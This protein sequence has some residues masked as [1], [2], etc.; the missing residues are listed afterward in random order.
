MEAAGAAVSFVSLAGPV[1]QGLKFLYDFTTDMKECPKEIREMRTDIDLVEDLITEVIQQC[2]G[3]DRRLRESAALA[4]AIHHARESVRDLGEELDKYR[5]DGKRQR[6]KFAVR[7]NQ[8]QKL[9]ASLNR[10]KTNMFEF[11]T[12]LQ[13]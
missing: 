4:R 11:K 5:V 10:T 7:L 8:T 9:R 6:F 2:N 12:Q 13:R 1:A 3:R